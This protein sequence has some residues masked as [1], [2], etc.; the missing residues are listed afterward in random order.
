[1]LARPHYSSRGLICLTYVPLAVGGR[2]RGL[3][4]SSYRT[5]DITPRQVVAYIELVQ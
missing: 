3:L 1:M 4:H 5:M 2:G